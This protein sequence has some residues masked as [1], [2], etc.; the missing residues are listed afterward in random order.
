MLP[1]LPA[2][3]TYEQIL[4]VSG[5]PLA[6]YVATTIH[7]CLSLAIIPMP[8]LSQNEFFHSRL[9]AWRSALLIG[10]LALLY[11][12]LWQP[13]GSYLAKTLFIAHLGLFILWQP[14]I[15]SKQQLT[16]RTIVLLALVVAAA[17]Y[18]LNGGL[19][20]L[21]IM[22]LAGIVGGKVLLSGEQGGR[23]IHLLALAYLVITLLLRAVPQAFSGANVTEPIALV[24]TLGLPMLLMAM[25]AVPQQ[26]PSKHT[27]EV[28]DYINS[29]FI[30][31]L[32]AVLVLGS[33]ATMLFFNSDY[34]TALLQTLIILG[35]VLLLLGW[36]WSPHMGF[37]GFEMLLSRY[38]MS[39]GLPAEQ[40]L[41]SLTDLARNVNEPSEFLAQSC[42]ELGK[43]LPWISGIEWTSS[44]THGSYGL[45][46]GSQRVFHHQNIAL[47]MYT[48][49]PLA[50][51]L[52]WHINLLAQIL[53]EFHADK[54]RA[55]QLKDLSYLQ[56]IHETGARLTHDVKNLLQSLQT[57]CRAAE[58]DGAENTPEFHALLRRQLP[59]IANRL[60]ATLDK[61]QIPQEEQPSREK[62]AQEWWAEVAQRHAHNHWI[63]FEPALL[64]PA[65]TLPASAFSSVLDNLI[66]NAADKRIR[67]PEL[68]VVITLKTAPDGMRLTFWDNGKPISPEIA[69]RLFRGPIHSAT[70]LGIGLFQAIRFAEQVGFTLNLDD[71]QRGH[72]CFSLVPLGQNR[73]N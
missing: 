3:S 52:V 70:G 32:L 24:G 37:S 60:G 13:A 38:L 54:Q 6:L 66:S 65:L 22:L 44:G 36:V 53:A 51:S 61:L 10:V 8:T 26:A 72:V 46:N 64:D 33:L 47:T 16:A 1:R 27:T 5:H 17:A 20:M 42:A 62:I 11:L 41:H 50:P 55:Q 57:L 12:V 30:F 31:L 9:T 14:F 23:L 73:P 69:A 28:I 39:V 21:W 35:C 43:R 40:W 68:S 25:M 56:A 71:N 15:E 59:V 2:L 18:F 58:E 7:G 48:R 67:E 45:P 63:R 4:T 29:V 19:I 34:A 49:Y